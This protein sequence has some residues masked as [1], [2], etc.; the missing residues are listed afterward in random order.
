MQDVQFDE[1]EAVALVAAL[2]G[3]VERG[4]HHDGGVDY[5]LGV[6]AP[7]DGDEYG[8]DEGEVAQGEHEQ[9]RPHLGLAQDVLVVGAVEAPVVA[10]AVAGREDEATA[11]VV[12]AP[13]V[14]AALDLVLL[15]ARLGADVN[16][17]P[18]VAVLGAVAALAAG[19]VATCALLEAAALRL[20]HAEG[21]DAQVPKT[22]FWIRHVDEVRHCTVGHQQVRRP[23]YSVVQAVARVR[24]RRVVTW[25]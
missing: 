8:R 14:L 16:L 4:E 1:T 5:G 15:D 23:V 9:T 13:A 12:H 19:R 25:R 7:S 21:P 3:V 20:V 22:W 17:G 6:V 2:A 18:G 24:H 10:V 11:H